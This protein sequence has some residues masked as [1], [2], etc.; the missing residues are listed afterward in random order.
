MQKKTQVGAGGGSV[1]T[2]LLFLQSQDVGY[3]N[4]FFVISAI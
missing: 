2:S 3:K 1:A 4:L